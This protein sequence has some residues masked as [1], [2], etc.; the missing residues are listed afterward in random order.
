MAAHSQGILRAAELGA[1]LVG[2]IADRRTEG[3]AGPAARWRCAGR[4][5]GSRLRSW[6]DGRITT[7]PICRST[8]SACLTWSRNRGRGTTHFILDCFVAWLPAL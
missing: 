6:P 8:A 3:K 2:I 4:V 5:A 1:S 7:R